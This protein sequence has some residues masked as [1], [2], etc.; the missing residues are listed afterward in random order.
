MLCVKWDQSGIVYY[1]H[2]KPGETVKAQGYRHQMIY[3]NHSLI[4]RQPEW[5]R[6]HG[7]V[8]LL[9]DIAPSHTAKPVKDT[10]KL[11]GWNI[12]SHLLYPSYL[13]PSDYPP[14]ASM[15]P[16]FAEQYLSNFEE[17]RKWL[18]EWFAAKDR[19]FFWQVFHKLP[20]R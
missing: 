2:L 11:L 8:I 20:E 4:E 1:E 3:L 16:V 19:Q 5:A 14:F 13:A 17:V 6:R 7:K 12:L 9:N 10:L 15:G 18:D